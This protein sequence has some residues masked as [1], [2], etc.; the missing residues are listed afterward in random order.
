MRTSGNTRAIFLHDN[1]LLPPLQGLVASCLPQSPPLP[2]VSLTQN[3]SAKC[4]V[5]VPVLLF[6]CHGVRRK[7]HVCIKS[8][9]I[10]GGPEFHV[11][12]E[13]WE[14]TRSFEEVKTPPPSAMQRGSKSTFLRSKPQQ[15]PHSPPQSFMSPGGSL[16]A[17]KQRLRAGRLQNLRA[18]P[19]SPPTG[20]QSPLSFVVSCLLSQQRPW[21]WGVPSISSHLLWG[22]FLSPRVGGCFTSRVVFWEHRQ[23]LARWPA[24]PWAVRVPGRGRRSEAALWPP[25]LTSLTGIW[26]VC[27]ARGAGRGKEGRGR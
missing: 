2:N 16:K 3:P 8:A 7:A 22:Q 27:G 12:R 13:M 14:G 11:L 19:A 10:E 9:K 18:A 6:P 26:S 23:H 1:N 15:A 20:A 5:S 25:Q 17:S 4:C 24:L 21:T